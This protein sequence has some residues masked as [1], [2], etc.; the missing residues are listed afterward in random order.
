MCLINFGLTKLLGTPIY[1][2]LDWKDMHSVYMS[3]AMVV[4]FGALYIILVKFDQCIKRN[5]FD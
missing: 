1:A 5:R 3:L 4:G 2:F